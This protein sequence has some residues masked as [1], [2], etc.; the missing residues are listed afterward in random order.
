V[1]IPT[2]AAA[3]ARKN[4]PAPAVPARLSGPAGP[5][6]PRPQEDRS[7]QQAAL[8]DARLSRDDHGRAANWRYLSTATKHGLSLFDALVMLT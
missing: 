7:L 4:I 2:P 1:G 6:S 3:A 8:A 5:A